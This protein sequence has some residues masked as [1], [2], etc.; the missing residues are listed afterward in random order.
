M[1]NEIIEAV[2]E[3]QKEISEKEET[4]ALIKSLDLSKPITEDVWRR[5]CETSLR[6]SPVMAELVKST[7]PEAGEIFVHSNSVHFMLYDFHIVIPTWNKKG[8]H[9]DTAWYQKEEIVPFK[10]YCRTT[11][12]VMRAVEFMKIDNPTYN[13]YLELVYG[14]QGPGIPDESAC[15]KKIF[16][17]RYKKSIQEMAN[18]ALDEAK[19]VQKA[20]DAYISSSKKENQKVDERVVLMKEKL[21]PELKRFSETIC[22]WDRDVFYNAYS[23]DQIIEMNEAS[24]LEREA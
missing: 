4:V 24:A 5:L 10:Q 22:G 6:T 2:E 3:L 16:Y 15:F 13:D 9:V 14:Y 18:D 11:R 23:P 20:Y 7:F 1:T 12:R 19:S 21:L 8:I 17:L